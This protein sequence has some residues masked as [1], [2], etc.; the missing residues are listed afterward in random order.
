MAPSV[1]IRSTILTLACKSSQLLQH[2]LSFVHLIL[3][4]TFLYQHILLQPQW[5]SSGSPNRLSCFMPWESLFMKLL[6]LPGNP[7]LCLSLP[8]P[9]SACLTPV[10]FLGISFRPLLRVL[11][12]VL[13][14]HLSGC[15]A[16]FLLSSLSLTKHAPFLAPVTFCFSICSPSFWNCFWTIFYSSLYLQHFA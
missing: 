14:P 15:I 6:P 1:R 13:S 5:R 4:H 8:H 12:G 9:K 3:L 2:A 10:Y 11:L 16:F 7:C